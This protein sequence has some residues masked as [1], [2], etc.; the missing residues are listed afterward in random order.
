M[1][2]TG[3][4]QVLGGNVNERMRSL[5]EFM[6]WRAANP[7]KAAEWDALHARYDAV[8]LALNAIA[9]VPR[10]APKPLNRLQKAVKN[11]D[12]LMAIVRSR[13]W[14][15]SEE[16]KHNLILLGS[17]GLGKTVAA[18]WLVERM[19]ERRLRGEVVC[20]YDL[21]GM[22]PW[23]DSASLNRFCSVDLL[24][25]DDFGKEMQTSATSEML[26]R[27][28]DR[29]YIEEKR[30]VITANLSRADLRNRFGASTSD[31]ISESCEVV[32]LSG[33]SRRAQNR[34]ANEP[35]SERRA[36]DTGRSA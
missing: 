32:D 22:S 6:D 19:H 16:R 18:L 29:R 30:T 7:A 8:D 5:R 33:E 36:L 15:D 12:E 31:R 2:A 24:V 21:S 23:N 14:L 35:N 11:P 4:P 27:I 17:H 1:D 9:R 10:E 20:A 34:R 3:Q 25:I 13:R 28:I 26:T